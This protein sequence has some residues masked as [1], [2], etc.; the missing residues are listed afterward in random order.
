M[1]KPKTLR[2]LLKHPPHEG[3]ARLENEDFEVN[4]GDVKGPSECVT[5]IATKPLDR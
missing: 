4:L 2:F 1:N 3:Y 5:L